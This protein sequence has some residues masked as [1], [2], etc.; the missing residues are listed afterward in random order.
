MYKHQKKKKKKKRFS[1]NG[2]RLEWQDSS[3]IEKIRQA[4]RGEMLEQDYK[5]MGQDK[6]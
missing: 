2:L 5:I 4:A 6:I 3:G 1:N